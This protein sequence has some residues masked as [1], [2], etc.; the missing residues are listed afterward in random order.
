MTIAVLQHAARQPR[1]ADYRRPAWLGGA[2]VLAAFGIFG[3]WA[4]YAPLDSAAVAQ[5]HIEVDSRHK[6]IQ[7]LEGG[8]VREILVKEAETVHEGQVLIRLDPTQARASADTVRKQTLAAIAREARLLT[9]L[10]GGREIVFPREL[11]EQRAKPE[12][13]V[14][15]EDELRRFVERRQ[16]LDNQLHMAETR[17]EQARQQIAG[18]SRQQAALS[19]QLASLTAELA[20]LKPLVDKGWHPRNRYMASEREKSR[21]EGELGQAT[22]D[23]ARLAKQQE[24]AQLQKDQIT[25]KFREEAARELAETRSQLSDLREKLS[26]TG[27]VLGRVEIRAPMG[28]VVQ[29]LK[30]GGI[31]SVI[32]PGEAVAELV[33]A[34]DELVVAAQVSPLDIDSVTAGATAEIRFTSMSTRRVPPVF[35]RV[36]S[37][38]ADAMTNE[39]SKQPYYLARVRVD[40]GALPAR[41]ARKLTPGMPADV[42]IASGDRSML[43]YLIGPLRDAIA[44]GMREE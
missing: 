16:S 14:G 18:R 19:A 41:I 34:E 33:P 27:D 23:I 1:L 29:N 10:D 11:M 25:Q 21:L 36:E 3:V 6:A 24:E 7:H 40:A 39:G 30:I 26:V 17:L 42:V 20:S 38:S 28:G 32:K 2:V 13:A 44:K 9:E 43:D 35:G 5:G 22:A 15:I 37:V 4:A 8:I 12:T 31:G